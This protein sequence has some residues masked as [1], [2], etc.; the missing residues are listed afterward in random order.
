MTTRASDPDR[1][2]AQRCAWLR[3]TLEPDPVGRCRPYVL[4]P[5]GAVYT[6]PD[7]RWEDRRW[8]TINRSP[9]EAWRIVRTSTDRPRTHSHSVPVHHTITAAE[10]DARTRARQARATLRRLRRW[11]DDVDRAI[12]HGAHTWT[13]IGFRDFV[14]GMPA[15][16][17]RWVLLRLLA[18][19][20]DGRCASCGTTPER[21]V[22]DHD[23]ESGLIRGA[24][25][26][27]CNGAEGGGFGADRRE[28]RLVAYRA[29]PP[30]AMFGWPFPGAG[31]R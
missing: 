14:L 2:L 22:L 28:L 6:R 3:S 7:R 27:G 30:A 18:H 23:H 15:P 20:Q 5:D 16:Q 4:T 1:W 9:G 11:Q 17:A 24:L 19:L 26:D 12:F 29:N 31:E 25:C 21:L 8:A 13:S 10:R